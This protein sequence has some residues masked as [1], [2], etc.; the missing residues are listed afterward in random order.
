MPDPVGSLLS[1]E[2]EYRSRQIVRQ[3]SALLFNLSL[4][5]FIV[6]LI[7]FGGLFFYRRVLETTRAD[8]ADQVK[9]REAE[10][11][12]EGGVGRLLDT[13][14][15]LGTARELIAKH[16]FPSNIFKLLE[17]VTLPRVQFSS[18]SY[19]RDSRKIDLAG[20]AAS[21]KT[22]ADEVRILEAH[23]QIEK[24][25]FGGLFVNDKNLVNFRL[26]VVFKPS[27]LSFLG[28][29]SAVGSQQP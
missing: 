22:V 26:A 23:P 7:A 3:G 18:F 4:V 16:V 13:A 2:H 10:F 20:V 29:S 12:A 1:K 5:L 17:E 11:N 28:E 15:A 6:A 21:Y 14:S 9:K 25:D 19:A 27:L 8:W 24:V